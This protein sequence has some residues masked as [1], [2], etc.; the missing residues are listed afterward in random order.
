M[1]EGVGSR[2]CPPYCSGAL[3]HL[4]QS[5]RALRGFQQ[6]LV[7]AGQAPLLGQGER[8]SPGSMGVTLAVASVHGGLP[9]C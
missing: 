1:L 5:V 9:G 8:A 4:A 7:P 6:D 2:G 3:S